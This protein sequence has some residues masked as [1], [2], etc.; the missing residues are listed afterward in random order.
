M[1]IIDQG[2][3]A[4]TTKKVTQPTFV[5]D[6]FPDGFVIL[7]YKD[8][9]PQS[10]DQ[11][12]LKGQFM[13]HQ[14]FTFGGEQRLVKEYYPGNSEPTVQ[15]LGP[16]ESDLKIKGG[17]RIKGLKRQYGQDSGGTS[18]EAAQVREFA[19]QYQE[20]IDAMRLRGNLVK[21][22]MGHWHR[23]GFIENVSFDMKTKADIA[24]EISFFIV[25][26]NPPKNS[27]IL[28]SSDDNLIQP[29]KDLTNA[30]LAAISKMQ[31]FPT[32]MPQSIADFLNGEISKV[33][34]AISLATNFVNSIVTSAEQIEASVNRAIGLLK[35]AR[36]TISSTGRRINAIATDFTSLGASVTNEWQKSIATVKSINHIN[37]MRG[38]FQTLAASLAALQAKMIALQTTVPAFRH[39]VRD[40]DTLQKISTKYYNTPD[41]WQKIMEHN[42]LTTTVLTSGTVLEIPKL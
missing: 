15:V 8:G 7:E 4:I 41:N 25:G 11:V 2:L 21:I 5:A 42:K 10:A 39:L 31:Q 38:N 9:R 37:D 26:F 28:T 16:K 20:L 35:N 22:T 36:S 13:P 23:W 19:L 18:I 1:S 14:P 30:A 29:N 40:G 32:D 27:K 12:V 33:A 24:Y 34:A 3:K 6:D 17:F